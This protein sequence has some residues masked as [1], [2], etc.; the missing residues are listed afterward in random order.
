MP[1]SA[2][3]SG[4]RTSRARGPQIPKQAQ[5][6]VTSWIRT[7]AVGRQMA[8][9][10]LAVVVAEGGAGDDREELLAQPGDG[11]V[12]LDAAASVQHLGVGDPAGLARDPV[13]AE[14]FEEGGRPG[15]LDLQLRERGLVEDGHPL[16]GRS[17]LGPDRRRPVLARP[18]P[19]P[20]RLVA[21][22][23]VRL[24]PVDPLPA[25]LLAEGRAVLAMPGVDRR[26]PQRPAGAALVVRIA[27]VVVGLVGLLDPRMG[28]GGR[29]VLG[30]EAADVHLPEVEAG[31]AVDDPLGHHLA[32]PAGAGE[33]VG[34][35]AGADEEARHLGLAEAEL[36]VGGERLGAV[37]QLGDR[38]LVHRRHPALGVLDDL[39]Q[40]VPVL[41]QQAAVEVGRDRSRRSPVP[42]GRKA[43][44]L[45]RS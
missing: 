18:A 15:S 44:S 28:V 12:A 26:D 24:V 2:G 40:A 27:D 13:V 22:R 14:A 31:L 20:Q 36:V 32:D 29:A 19:R 41:F 34:A 16:P 42:P 5:R 23:G 45:W 1:R 21:R 39:L 17:V 10:P 37:D 9:H 38:D 25:R 4:A 3:V 11:E 8:A 7:P 35:E 33:T 43:G 6:E 30:A